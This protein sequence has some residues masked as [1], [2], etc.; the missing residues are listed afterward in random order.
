MIRLTRVIGGSVIISVS[1][2][3]DIPAF[4]AKWFINRIRAGYCTV[5]NPFNKNQISYISLK[6]EDV[7]VIVF[8]SRNPA[9][10]IPYLEE[11]NQRGY[12]Y[13][14]QFTV[15]NNPR[16]L[17][18]KSPSISSSIKTFKKLAN[19]I[20]SQRVI[21]RY[22]PI[23]LSDATDIDF[24]VK[25]YEKIAALLSSYTHRSVISIMD[26]YAK[27]NKR[28]REIEN[29][30]NLNI[31]N[32]DSSQHILSKLLPS[33]AKISHDNGM[34]IFSC[35]EKIDFSSYGILP[36]KCVDDEYIE[37]VF[38]LSV[39]HKKDTAQR[40]ACGCVVSKDIGMYDTCLFGCQYCY[41]TTNFKKSEENNRKHDFLSPSLIGWHESK[42]NPQPKQL[43][44]FTD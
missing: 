4:Y 22:D 10:L 28:L 16:F 26:G 38:N 17:D 40:E 15:M 39:S 30:H 32:I 6:P 34:E 41:A 8:W 25:A 14:F 43:R 35:A 7:D 23:V 5:P 37:K 11:L 36:G 3:T 20:G 19:H 1:R 29:T 12:R 24:H 9:P 27:N 42:A 33:L 31:L 21:W 44:L 18:T 2:R 13:Y